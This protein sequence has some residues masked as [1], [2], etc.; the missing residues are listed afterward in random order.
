M[1][2]NESLPKSQPSAYTEVRDFRCLYITKY[3]Q[4]IFVCSEG[5]VLTLGT[6]YFCEVLVAVNFGARNKFLYGFMFVSIYIIESVCLL[7][8]G[9]RQNYSMD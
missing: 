1:L 4:C 6:M 8:R 5:K 7:V 2:Y 9:K 3:I